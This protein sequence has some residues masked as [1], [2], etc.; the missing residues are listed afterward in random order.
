[1]QVFT[2][3]IEQIIL[4][5][6]EK[7]EKS[8]TIVVAWFTNKWIIS[9][10][11]DLKKYRN[12]DIQILVDDNDVNQSY[13]FDLHLDNL[14]ECGIEVKRQHISKFNHN[15][16]SVIDNET[17][18]TGSYNYT[19]KANQN[20]ENIVVEKDSRIADFYT[21]IFK[22]FTDKNYIDPNVELLSENFD[23][24]NKLISTY[25]PFS[26]K[27]FLKLK[28]QINL[29]YCFTHENG[30]YN[31]ISYEPGLIFNPKFKLHKELNNRINQKK[32]AGYPD[33]DYN[34]DQEFDLPITKGLILNYRLSEINNFNY[35]T[36]QEIANFD[37][38]KI[39]YESFAND[40]VSN[41][42]ALTKYYTRKFQTIYTSQELREI[43]QKNIDIV[44]EDYIWINN[45]APFLNETTIENIYKTQPI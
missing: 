23:F 26:Q 35:Q 41:E 34:L 1:M 18:I 17:F 28:S 33:F 37:S 5:H 27:L 38:E 45:F 8:I 9:K 42:I 19:N 36:L 16:F 12:L 44:I 21:R 40:V 25:Y 39:D 7:A 22:F 10:L 20:F 32:S 3:N 13:F 15:K 6:F 2:Q 11:I 4:E 24:A 14:E 43:L 31:E 30:L 29:G